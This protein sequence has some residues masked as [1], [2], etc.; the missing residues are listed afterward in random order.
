MILK[1]CICT[2][3]FMQHITS[4]LNECSA[5]RMSALTYKRAQYLHTLPMNEVGGQACVVETML[6]WMQGLSITQLKKEKCD[7]TGCL[8]RVCFLD[9]ILCKK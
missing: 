4:P 3:Y 9:R 2:P 6:I 5:L 1:Y 7:F 8:F